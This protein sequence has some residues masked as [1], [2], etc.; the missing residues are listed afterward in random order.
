M[1]PIKESLA[2]ILA[3]YMQA[4][5]RFLTCIVFE[6]ILIVVLSMLFG[7]RL[8]FLI[9]MKNF[10]YLLHLNKKVIM[11]VKPE[12]ESTRRRGSGAS[13]SLNNLVLPRTTKFPTHEDDHYFETLCLLVSERESSGLEF[14]IGILSR[15]S[16]LPRR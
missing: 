15:S 8:I 13:A 2:A 7:W 5:S 16:P 11:F 3:R 6:F 10:L 9:V 1:N 14:V 4:V 12:Q